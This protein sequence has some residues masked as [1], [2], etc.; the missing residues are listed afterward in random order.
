MLLYKTWGIITNLTVRNPWGI[1]LICQNTK[2]RVHGAQIEI[3]YFY[4]QKHLELLA[5][6]YTPANLRQASRGQASDWQ[7]DRQTDWQTH[8]QTQATTIPEGQNWPR[9]KMK[10]YVQIQ[11]PAYTHTRA[12]ISSKHNDHTKMQLQD[13][14]WHNDK[15]NHTRRKISNQTEKINITTHVNTK[16]RHLSYDQ[17]SD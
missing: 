15:Q 6:C 14:K 4:V 9:V 13:I 16:W 10:S 7:T 1:F 11:T 3:Y 5:I 12:C 2:M 8:T 17:I